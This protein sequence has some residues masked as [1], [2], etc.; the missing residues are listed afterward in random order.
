MSTKVISFEPGKVYCV[1]VDNVPSKRL[2]LYQGPDLPWQ[3]ICTGEEAAIAS[4]AIQE[5][6]EVPRTVVDAIRLCHDKRPL[7]VGLPRSEF[8]EDVEPWERDVYWDV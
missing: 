2:V 6:I 1:G 5:V 3:D 8:N 7:P 4:E